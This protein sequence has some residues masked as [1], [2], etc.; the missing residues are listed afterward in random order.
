MRKIDAFDADWIAIGLAAVAL[1]A[2]LM[3][4]CAGAAK[5]SGA[6]TRPCLRE[7]PARQKLQAIADPDKMAYV[8][9]DTGEPRVALRITVDQ[10]ALRAFFNYVEALEQIARDALGCSVN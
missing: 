2:A 9:G 4:G 1:A 10:I 6:P 5:I 3:A 8:D 7:T